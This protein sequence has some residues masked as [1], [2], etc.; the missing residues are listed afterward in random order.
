MK[1]VKQ[2]YC[3]NNSTFVITMLDA[4]QKLK[5]YWQE[6]DIENMLLDGQKLF[7]PFAEYEIT[8]MDI[9]DIKGVRL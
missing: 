3:H 8:D 9:T 2:H 7:T 4:V 6:G 1:N 5:G